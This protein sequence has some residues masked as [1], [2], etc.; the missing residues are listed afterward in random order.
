MSLKNKINEDLNTALKAK[1]AVRIDTLRSVRAEILKMDKS[2]M[3]REMNEEEE[4]QLLNKQA[5]MRR[6]SIEMFAGA[7][8]QDLVEK[9]NAQLN[10]LGEY[11]PKQMTEEEAG[12]IVE[13]ILLNFP[14]ASQK[15]LGKIMGE[16]MKQLKGKIDG[17]V[18][19]E[20][21]KVRL[22]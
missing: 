2:G 19:Q 7:G 9:E 10:V 15:D 11:L 20:I 13:K 5:K 8:R 6:E 21:V 18:L 12:V 17:K 3:N 22:T 16:V 1:D 4:L 14:D